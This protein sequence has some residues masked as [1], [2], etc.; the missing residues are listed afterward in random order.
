MGIS[1]T[2]YVDRL[3]FVVYMCADKSCGKSVYI[4]P[5]EEKDATLQE[6]KLALEVYLKRTVENV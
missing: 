5:V 4:K 2:H 3:E 1:V 6:R